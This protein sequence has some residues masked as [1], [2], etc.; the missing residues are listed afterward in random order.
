M[1]RGRRLFKPQTVLLRWRGLRGGGSKSGDGQT[2]GTGMVLGEPGF[3]LGERGTR[4][5]PAAEARRGESLFS[6]ERSIVVID[7]PICIPSTPPFVDSEAV[8]QGIRTPGGWVSPESP[9]F[10]EPRPDRE[11]KFFGLSAQTSAKC[12]A[13]VLLTQ[14]A[15]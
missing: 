14:F 7:P 9:V 4:D 5:P 2:L 1:R 11:L 8:R 13:G 15:T 3:V 6:Q 12:L 10:L